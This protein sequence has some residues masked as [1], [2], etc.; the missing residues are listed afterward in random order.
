MK[1]LCS[2][3]SLKANSNADS[4]THAA[5]VGRVREIPR[6]HCPTKVS[7]VPNFTSILT[8]SV[9][10]PLSSFPEIKVGV[11]SLYWNSSPPFWPFSSPLPPSENNDQI[12]PPAFANFPTNIVSLHSWLPLATLCTNTCVLTM[13]LQTCLHLSL[14]NFLHLNGKHMTLSWPFPWDSG[15]V[16]NWDYATPWARKWRAHSRKQVHLVIQLELHIFPCT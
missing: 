1:S 4:W 12:H 5:C 2:Q 8:L 15:T 16:W 10:H 7:Q 3:R 11:P 9:Q 14:W 13:K 6:T